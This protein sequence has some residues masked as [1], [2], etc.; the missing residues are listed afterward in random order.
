MGRISQAGLDNE[1]Q[2]QQYQEGFPPIVRIL[3]YGKNAL[4]ENCVS[5]T[6]L[7]IQLTQNSP[8]WAYIG[9]NPQKV[10]TALVE[11]ALCGD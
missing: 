4:R 11:T 8:T 1:V 3:V 10:E 7:M 5:G 9:Q 6:V 2:G